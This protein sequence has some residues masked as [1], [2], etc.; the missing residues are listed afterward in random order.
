MSLFGRLRIDIK[1]ENIITKIE[2][3]KAEKES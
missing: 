3:Q 1:K 2:E